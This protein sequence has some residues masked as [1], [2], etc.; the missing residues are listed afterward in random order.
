MAIPRHTAGVR[1][2]WLAV[3][4]EDLDATSRFFA[5]GVGMTEDGRLP[6]WIHLT[7]EDFEVEAFANPRTPERPGNPPRGAI[8]AVFESDDLE[9]DLARL[10]A[11]G[12]IVDR[13][14]TEDWGRCTFVH[15]PGG[16][17]IQVAQLLPGADDFR[18]DYASGEDDRPS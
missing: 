6:S 13:T 2:R 8:V 17:F 12:G 15:V 3:Q 14:V 4:T 18:R 1:I 10:A 16:G 9:A 5:E 11:A 7:G